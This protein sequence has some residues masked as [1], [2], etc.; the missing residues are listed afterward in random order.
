MQNLEKIRFVIQV[1]KSCDIKLFKSQS[2]H[3][4]NIIS[5]KYAATT[6]YQVIDCLKCKKNPFINMRESW[7]VTL[8]LKQFRA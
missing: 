7:K 1:C 5:F 8:V 6:R 3:F 4:L 2:G